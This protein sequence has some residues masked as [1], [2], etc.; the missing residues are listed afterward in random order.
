MT[1]PRN[2]RGPEPASGSD[3]RGADLGRSREEPRD[4][5]LPHDAQRTVIALPAIV[6][7]VE[8]DQPHGW[9]V[10]ARRQ[11]EVVFYRSAFG[12]FSTAHSNALGLAVERGWVLA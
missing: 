8:P 6:V 9:H 7:A 1:W 4:T 11:G 5:D 12:A 3:P 2:G 10:R